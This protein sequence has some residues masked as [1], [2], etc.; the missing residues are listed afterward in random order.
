MHNAWSLLQALSPGDAVFRRRTSAQRFVA[1][2]ALAAM[3][4]I[5]VV[6]TVSRSLVALSLAPP[7]SM[8][9]DGGMAM[10]GMAHDPASHAAGRRGHAMPHAPVPPSTDACGYCVLM[11]HSPAL[12]AVA[13]VLLPL[14]LPALAPVRPAARR[15]PV[16]RRL[17]VRSRGPPLA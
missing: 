1:W 17:D 11:Y 5:A 9:M 12:A 16:P 15:A 10:P 14:R 6:P 8:A 4:L 7:M 3:A 2:L 13:L